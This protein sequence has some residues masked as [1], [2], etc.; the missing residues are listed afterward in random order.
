MPC[1]SSSSSTKRDV[2]I[3]VSVPHCDVTSERLPAVDADCIIEK[4][5]IPRA[6]HAVSDQVPY[7]T[8]KYGEKYKDYTVLQQHVLFWDRDGDGLITPWD[9]YTGFR[10]LG[11]NPPFSLMGMHGS[12]TGVYDNEG[13]FVPQKFEDLF[14]K[15]DKDGDGSL[16][17]KEILNM[18]HGNRVAGDLFG[19]I[20]PFFE[21]GTTWTLLQQEGRIHKEDLRQVYDGSIFWRIRERRRNG[22]GW[23]QGFGI[24]GDGFI[25]GVKMA[26]IA[27]AKKRI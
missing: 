12:D 21:W 3:T 17:L 23:D 2:D 22:M 5:G 15:W 10:E 26:H 4:P 8:R 6:N 16:N 13:R 7:G 25:G 14:T 1:S 11:F 19:W 18:M 9:T 27:A 20:V 24:G